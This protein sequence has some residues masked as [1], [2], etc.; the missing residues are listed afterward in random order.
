MSTDIVAPE[1]E[2]IDRQ[3]IEVITNAVRL[4][5]YEAANEWAEI[6]NLIA[7]SD[8]QL[9]PEIEAK[10]EA[11][12]KVTPSIFSG[13]YILI[14]EAEAEV[15]YFSP[16]SDRINGRKQAAA[17]RVAGFRSMAKEFMKMVGEDRVDTPSRHTFRLQ[18]GPAVIKWTKTPE[19]APPEY[20]IHVIEVDVNKAKAVLKAGGELPEGFEVV[21][22]RYVVID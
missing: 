15:N 13:L 1:N 2:R 16:E 5:L 17:K 19:D 18:D 14:R 12:A 4:Q 3:A 7:A 11:I 20:Q 21:R 9:T 22:T 8:G 6:Q 10:I